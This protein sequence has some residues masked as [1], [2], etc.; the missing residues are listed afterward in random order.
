V[1]KRATW[2]LAASSAGFY[3]KKAL[4]ENLSGDEVYNTNS[5]TL[6]VKNVL[7][8]KLYC[9]GLNLVIFSYKIGGRTTP[10]STAQGS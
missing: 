4:H 10:S 8:I 2:S 6:L 7:W 9:Q 1:E 3:M 5:L